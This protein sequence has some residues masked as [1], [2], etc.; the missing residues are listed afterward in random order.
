M[1]GTQIRGL[2][3]TG[4]LFH[5]LLMKKLYLSDGNGLRRAVLNAGQTI[6]ALGHIYR[7]GLFSLQLE[8]LLGADSYTGAAA[9]ALALVH[10]YHVHA[11][12]FLLQ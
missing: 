2:V 3:L 9:V 1:L 6:D 11:A 5:D 4:P 7:L 12:C 8:H 10:C